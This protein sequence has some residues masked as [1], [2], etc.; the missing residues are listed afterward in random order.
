MGDLYEAV[1][2]VESTK[3]VSKMV[4][5]MCEKSFMKHRNLVVRK[6]KPC[7]EYANQ[8]E[9]LQVC[10]HLHAKMVK[11]EA[12]QPLWLINHGEFTTFKPFVHFDLDDDLDIIGKRRWFG[13]DITIRVEFKKVGSC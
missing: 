12:C 5:K 7:F 4:R 2:I 8:Y 10:A 9:W 1:F 6:L 13:R 3:P 11:V